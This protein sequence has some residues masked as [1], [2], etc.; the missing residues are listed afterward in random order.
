MERINSRAAV[1]CG[2]GQV[3]LQLE[4][5]SSVGGGQAGGQAPCLSRTDN[6]L[7]ADPAR[8]RVEYYAD[9]ADNAG[10]GRRRGHGGPVAGGRM[11]KFRGRAAGG[12]KPAAGPVELA[13]RSRRGPGAIFPRTRRW[14]VGGLAGP[15]YRRGPFRAAPGPFGGGPK[16]I[17]CFCSTILIL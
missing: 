1:G 4:V 13:L 12:K 16:I 9:P 5:R 8:A 14:E 7:H 11:T 15:P 10:G 2:Q 3:E 6:W 17:F